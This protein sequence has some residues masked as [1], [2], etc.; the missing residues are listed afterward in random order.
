MYEDFSWTKLTRNIAPRSLVTQLWK[1]INTPMVGVGEEQRE[2]VE[3]VR[4]ECN[5]KPSD[6]MT[7][8]VARMEVTSLILDWDME[9]REQRDTV[10]TQ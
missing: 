10:V 8:E 7:G 3:Y 2:M 5:T 1:F 4:G 6:S 9:A